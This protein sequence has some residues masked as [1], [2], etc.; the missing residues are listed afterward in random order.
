MIRTIT[1][2]TSTGAINRMKA[3]LKM[4]T[5]MPLFFFVSSCSEQVGGGPRQTHH[6]IDIA[7]PSTMPLQ[8]KS[9]RY[10]TG[11]VEKVTS[12]CPRKHRLP[13]A[14]TCSVPITIL[15]KRVSYTFKNIILACSN[16]NYC[17]VLRCIWPLLLTHVVLGEN[18]REKKYVGNFS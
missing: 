2:C 10:Q 3:E 1:I 17:T 4:P 12:V 11:A 16:K 6:W 14:T 13:G 7:T 15:D 5:S 8:G 18:G 9:A